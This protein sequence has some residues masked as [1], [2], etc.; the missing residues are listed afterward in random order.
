MAVVTARRPAVSA[1]RLLLPSE[2]KGHLCPH[3]RSTL[4][5]AR[6]PAALTC[7]TRR[8]CH[9]QLIHVKLED[10]PSFKDPTNVLPL[11]LDAKLG[12]GLARPRRGIRDAR[13]PP[14]EPSP[15]ARRGA[16]ASPRARHHAGQRN[17]VCQVAH[18]PHH[19]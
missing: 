1:A 6:S 17:A 16:Y 10:W 4:V 12:A 8:S 11:E 18:C 7:P 3:V 19:Q 2:P 15:V 5:L 14:I 13:T 9:S